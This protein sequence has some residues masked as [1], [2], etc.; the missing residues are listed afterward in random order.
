MTE[1]KSRNWST[2]TLAR[3]LLR[4]L[5]GSADLRDDSSV[6]ELL[7]ALKSRIVEDEVGLNF[8]LWGKS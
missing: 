2:K 7:E 4:F 1:P 8:D 3:E 5:D 6:G